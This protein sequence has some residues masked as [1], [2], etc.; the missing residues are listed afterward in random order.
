MATPTAGWSSWWSIIPI[1]RAGSHHYLTA[2]K[3]P[4]V[5]LL[6]RDWEFL[7]DQLKSTHTVAQYFEPAASEA[8][9]LGQEPCAL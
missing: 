3:H 8:L 7:F 2:R 5:V 1:H 4:A 9:E 6:R